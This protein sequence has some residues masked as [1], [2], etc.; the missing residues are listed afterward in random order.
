MCDFKVR[1]L[2]IFQKREGQFD[3]CL[4]SGVIIYTLLSLPLLYFT[5][6]TRHGKL[7]ARIILGYIKN[8]IYFYF[9]ISIALGII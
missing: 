2:G 3:L 4:Y 6:R 9:Y 8:I 1:P 7:Q 5:N